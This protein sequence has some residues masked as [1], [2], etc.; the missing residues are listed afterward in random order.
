MRTHTPHT[1]VLSSCSVK[2]FPRL[3]RPPAG[4]SA[5]NSA[6]RGTR[7]VVGW[8]GVF[9]PTGCLPHHVRVG[10]KG[11]NPEIHMY[12]ANGPAILHYEMVHPLLVLAMSCICIVCQEQSLHEHIA[13]LVFYVLHWRKR[14]PPPYNSRRIVRRAPSRAGALA[15]AWERRGKDSAE[16]AQ[17]CDQRMHTFAR[18]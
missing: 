15:G 13:P 17:R 11:D 5:L 3:S 7:R 2:S 16:C 9:S 4:G 10:L 6:Q 18:K 8:Q 1:S 14:A 12:H